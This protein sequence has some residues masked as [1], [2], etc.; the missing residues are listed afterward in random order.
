MKNQAISI[1]LLALL[2][3]VSCSKDITENPAISQGKLLKETYYIDS[4][5]NPIEGFTIFEYDP[6][7]NLILKNL[8]DERLISYKYDNQSR[9]ILERE[10]YLGNP[11]LDKK[12]S[13]PSDLSKIELVINSENDTL[14]KSEYEFNSE[15]KLIHEKYFSH[16]S[17]IGN[18]ENKLMI[19]SDINYNYHD[20]GKIK[21]V[22]KSNYA[23]NNNEITGITIFIDEFNIQGDKISSI[24]KNDDNSVFLNEKYTNIYNKDN[25]LIE[26]YLNSSMETDYIKYEYDDLKR[27]IK[28]YDYNGYLKTVRIY[29][30]SCTYPMELHTYLSNNYDNIP[31]YKEITV[32][33]YE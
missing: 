7:G 17:I 24:G 25:L 12:Y 30:N 20:N 16:L 22:T 1:N 3:V 29:E 2:S 15:M 32:Y 28:T 26:S 21:F 9:I 5:D 31:D 23:Y 13:Y 33:T 6:A 27:L 4:K 18:N 19:F 11:V 8:K 14:Y 10:L